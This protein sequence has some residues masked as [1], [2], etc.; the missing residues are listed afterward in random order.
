MSGEHGA[1]GRGSK[2]FGVGMHRTGTTSLRRAFNLLGL[3]CLEDEGCWFLTGLDDAGELVFRPT[4]EIDRY[5]AFADNPVPLFVAELDAAFPGSRFVL[6]HRETEAWLDSVEYIFAAWGASWA[7]LAEAPLVDAC[8]RALYGGSRFDRG[9]ARDAYLRHN[10]R[11]RDYFARRPG[12][13]LELD[14]SRPVDWQ[15]LCRFLDREP[16]AA[17]YPRLN[18]RA[19]DPAAGGS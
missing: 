17:P 8:H 19:D 5:D 10:A 1:K 15:P 14:V 3:R 6:T 11:V 4:A 18:R 12:D 7:E 9:R 2:V 16:P 13:L